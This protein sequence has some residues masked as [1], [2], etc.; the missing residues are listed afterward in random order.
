[1]AQGGAHRGGCCLLLFL[2]LLALSLRTSCVVGQQSQFKKIYII[3]LGERR[4]DDP[5]IVTGSHH[6]MLASV[7]GRFRRFRR[8]RFRRRRV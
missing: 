3:Y 1:M 7:L 5:D 6:D 8:V 2:V 4:H